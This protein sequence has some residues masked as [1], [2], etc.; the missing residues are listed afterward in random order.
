M[1]KLGA[2]ELLADLWADADEVVR[3]HL[4]DQE[5]LQQA[6]ALAARVE[7]ALTACERAKTAGVDHP[8]TVLLAM[9]VLRLLNGEEDP[10]EQHLRAHPEF[11]AKP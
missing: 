6:Y 7:K 2:R 8:D 3:R 5:K 10:N 9:R 11:G 4:T 1:S